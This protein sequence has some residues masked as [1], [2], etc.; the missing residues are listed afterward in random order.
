MH[1]DG[2]DVTTFPSSF[3]GRRI[4]VCSE[5]F[6]P[7]N[8]V[9]RTTLMT[10]DHLESHGV[11]VSIPGCCGEIRLAGSRVP[12]NSELFVVYPVQLS[13]IYKR[14]FGGPPDLIYLASP[15]ALGFRTHI[16]GCNGILLST[17]FGQLA[18]WVI[19]NIESTPFHHASVKT[20][21]YPSLSSRSHLEGIAYVT[22]L[23]RTWAPNREYIL[24]TCSRLAGEKEYEFLAP[25]NTTVEEDIK[26]LFASLVDGEL[27][28]HY[29]SAGVLLHCSIT[30]TF[31]LIVLEAMASGV[32][33]IA[34][35]DT[36]RAT[37]IG[38]RQTGYLVLPHDLDGFVERLEETRCAQ[39][40]LETWN[41][42]GN[43]VAWKMMG[44]IKDQERATD[45]R[46]HTV[47]AALHHDTLIHNCPFMSTATRVT[48]IGNAKS[49]LG[50]L[51]Y[52]L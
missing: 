32:P 40:L 4:P 45:Y 42:I 47:T 20:I 7:V 46:R 1:A 17:P 51:P 43:T 8:G 27:M 49:T 28:V 34:R 14:T 35:E 11:L 22:K 25:K 5:S 30:E 52:L 37:N 15:A 21:S 3:R 6:G 44:A 13:E 24:L 23:Q 19:A 36:G 16:A 38:N 31:G 33:V 29:A 10:V 39:A 18:S 50:K 26:G 2:C 9:S 41:A 12:F 48:C